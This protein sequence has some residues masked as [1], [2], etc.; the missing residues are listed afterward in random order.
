MRAALRHH[1]THTSPLFEL[2][3]GEAVTVLECH[4][5]QVSVVTH[6]IAF[7]VRFAARRLRGP[8]AVRRSVDQPH[9]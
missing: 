8:G 5:P 7:H 4:V 9:W 2:T 6:R 1:L 3:L